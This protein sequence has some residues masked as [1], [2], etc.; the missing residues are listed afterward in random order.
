MDT[1]IIASSPRKGMF[2]DRIAEIAKEKTKG[3]I[4]HLRE[5]KIGFCHACDYCKEIKKGSCIQHDDM[6]PLYD[7][8]RESD[9]IYL[10]SPIYWWQVNGQ[11]KAFIDRLYALEDIDWK[12]K[13]VAVILNGAAEDNDRE[14]KILED[15]FNEM[16]EYLGVDYTFLGVGTRDEN[17]FISKKDKIATFIEKTSS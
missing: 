6:T 3:S 4:V 12:N 14:F 13:K 11:M 7:D 2:S 15:A 5:R 8:I 9:I 10:I 16:F 17:D 1:L